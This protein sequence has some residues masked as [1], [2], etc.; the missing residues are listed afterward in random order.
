M[1]PECHCQSGCT[2]QVNAQDRYFNKPTAAS[3]RLDGFSAAF[4]RW[5]E[6]AGTVASLFN[7][8]LEPSGPGKVMAERQLNDT[9]KYQVTITLN[10]NEIPS[11]TYNV[12]VDPGPP[13]A[14]Q[15]T[16]QVCKSMQCAACAITR[17]WARSCSLSALL[18]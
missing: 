11:G 1:Q 13:D 14:V 16:M 12:S 15:S 17:S 18:S 6:T 7:V 9:G 2:V 8:E 10:G 5:N 3:G 4:A